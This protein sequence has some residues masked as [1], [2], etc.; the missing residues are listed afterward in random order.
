MRGGWKRTLTAL[1]GAAIAVQSA[2]ATSVVLLSENKMIDGASLIVQGTVLSS[3]S[4]FRNGLVKVFTDVSIEVEDVLKGTFT[5]PVLHVGLPGGVV[6]GT[7]VH[8]PGVPNFKPGSQVVVF[9]T[10]VNGSGYTTVGLSQGKYT[11]EPDQETGLTVA[12]QAS[13][14]ALRIPVP[15]P[16]QTQ[17]QAFRA[18]APQVDNWDVFRRRIRKRVA[19]GADQ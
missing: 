16:G 10:Q 14:G 9:L 19:D 3:Q 2:F 11:L 6:D 17:A 12:I 4:A 15:L 18:M 5:D 1:A 13:G 7:T 8:I